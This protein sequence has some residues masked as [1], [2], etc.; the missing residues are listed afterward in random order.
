MWDCKHWLPWRMDGGPAPKE[1]YPPWQQMAPSQ[2]LQDLPLSPFH[3]S[4]ELGE[5]WCRRLSAVPS[6]SSSLSSWLLHVCKGWD[7]LQWEKSLLQPMLSSSWCP[8]LSSCCIVVTQ[9]ETT[10]PGFLVTALPLHRALCQGRGLWLKTQ[11]R[12]A[13]F[14]SGTS[15]AT[16]IVLPGPAPHDTGV[17]LSTQS[18]HG[19]MDAT[20][21]PFSDTPSLSSL[22]FSSSIYSGFGDLRP[23]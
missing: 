13:E 12:N 19:E 5:Q 3:C 20:A 2:T 6:S 7:H 22:C 11:P 14:V 16:Y 1:C 17:T 18:L 23:M 21:A 9:P 8:G 4:M 10:S 15:F